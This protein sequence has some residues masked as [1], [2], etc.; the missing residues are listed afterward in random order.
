MALINQFDKFVV[1]AKRQTSF[2]PSDSKDG[3]PQ[4]Y[5]YLSG[6]N[7][8]DGSCL[9]DVPISEDSLID[10]DRTTENTV[11]DCVFNKTIIKGEKNATRTTSV[12]LV[13]RVGTLEVKFETKKA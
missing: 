12:K 7:A 4:K 9:S 11:Y 8:V 13:S 5:E 6:F 3:K 10:F 2:V 1:T